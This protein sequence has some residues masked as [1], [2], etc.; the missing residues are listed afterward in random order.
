[1]FLCSKKIQGNVGGARFKWWVERDLIHSNSHH[2]DTTATTASTTAYADT[3]TFS[4]LAS[5]AYTISVVAVNPAGNSVAA[6][7]TITI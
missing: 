7:T 2:S 5:G 4:S 6:T 1:M 3:H